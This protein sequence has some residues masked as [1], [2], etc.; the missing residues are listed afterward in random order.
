MKPFALLL[1]IIVIVSGLHGQTIYTIKTS[2]MNIRGTSTMHDWELK[3]TTI[4]GNCVMSC[5]GKEIRDIKSFSL[6]IP[7]KSLKSV[8]GSKMMDDKVYS[9][10][11]SETVQNITFKLEKIVS[12]TPSGNG[13]DV[14]AS[15][16]LSIAGV[17]SNDVL[18]VHITEEQNGT[19]TLSGVKKLKMKDY[20]VDPPK[21]MLGA[22]TTGNEIQIEF[23]INLTKS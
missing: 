16:S 18:V 5:E 23:K 20:N 17:S 12:I 4:N 21:A 6:T 22:L 11:K 3:A 19:F 7:T 13:W 2:D 8:N 15:G 14:T 9:A 10:L 1:I